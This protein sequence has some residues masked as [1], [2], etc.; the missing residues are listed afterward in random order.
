VRFRAVVAA[1]V[2]VA[3]LVPLTAASAAPTSI[4]WGSA[5]TVLHPQGGTRAISCPSSTFCMVVDESGRAIPIHRG[6]PGPATVLGGSLESVSCHSQHFCV[7]GGSDGQVSVLRGAQW[8]THTMPGNAYV[9]VS[10]ASDNFCLALSG[11]SYSR[12]NGRAWTTP[13]AYTPRVVDFSEISCTSASYC[14]AVGNR[15]DPTATNSFGYRW[16]DGRWR[17]GVRLRDTANIAVTSISCVESAYCLTS[18]LEGRMYRYS[19]GRWAF[20][21]YLNLDDPQLSCAGA[22]FCV[23]AGL[24]S[25][26][27]GIF[28]TRLGHGSWAPRHRILAAGH[29]GGSAVSCSSARSCSAVSYTGDESRWTGTWSRPHVVD[30]AEGG[31]T[32]GPQVSCGSPRLCVEVDEFGNYLTY[33][34]HSWTAPRRINRNAL[35]TLPI[36]CAGSRFCLTLDSLGR[37]WVYDGSSWHATAGTPIAYGDNAVLAL[38]CVTSTFCVAV[39]GGSAAVFNGRTWSKPVRYDADEDQVAGISCTPSRFCGVL[40]YYAQ[41][42]ELITYSHSTWHSG[43]KVPTAQTMTNVAC[44]GSNFCMITGDSSRDVTIHRGNSF[45]S[46]LAAA[47]PEGPSC[48]SASFCVVDEFGDYQIWN[49]ADLGAA[50]PLSDD[51]RSDD[52]SISC[53]APSSCATVGLTGAVVGH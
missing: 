51:I 3:S 28:E 44:A 4:N 50:Q 30:H 13:N 39:N 41:G 7:V 8:S 12:Y 6:V 40:E 25:S 26:H 42:Q 10:C 43:V 31:N 45:T 18:D 33:D 14:V 53:V 9:A 52:T 34:G 36:S 20:Y 27:E 37:G 24:V 1:L 17:A 5:T 49:G 46:V 15:L 2:L 29:L 35:G 47:G 16:R 38:S 32:I 11:R 21:G 23:A 48:I 22:G 19:R